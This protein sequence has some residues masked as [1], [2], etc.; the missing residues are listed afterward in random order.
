M[1]DLFVRRP[2]LA[3]VVAGLFWALARW[4]HRS[5][6]LLAA[7][8]WFVYA[9]YELLMRYRVLCSGE[10]NIRVDLLGIYPIL[11]AV[12]LVALL[13]GL[14]GRRRAPTQEF[15]EPRPNER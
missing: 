4:S 15:L 10:C 3:L 11:A 6:A 13:V 1:L 2:A 5:L 12:S 14:F 9:I 8:A 7:V